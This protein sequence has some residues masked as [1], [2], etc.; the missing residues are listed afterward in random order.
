MSSSRRSPPS[1]SVSEVEPDLSASAPKLDAEIESIQPTHDLIDLLAVAIL[2]VN[3][4][5]VA[6][7]VG[8]GVFTGEFAVETSQQQQQQGGDTASVDTDQTNNGQTTISWTEPGDAIQLEIR[9]SEGNE[10]DTLQVV[11]QETTVAVEEF[12][13]YARYPDGTTEQVYSEG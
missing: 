4:V 10:I 9:N 13:V 11:G 8:G 7:V 12:D 5:S 6:G 3:V 2:L 1:P